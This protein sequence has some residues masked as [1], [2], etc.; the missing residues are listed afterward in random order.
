MLY[1]YSVAYDGF[2]NLHLVFGI[3]NLLDTDPSFS[4]HQ[5]DYSPGAAFDARIGD[6]RGRAYTLLMEY[7]F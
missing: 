7:D 4:A 5:N 1:N 3:K 2:D 6:P